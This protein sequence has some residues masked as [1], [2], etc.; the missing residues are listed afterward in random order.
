MRPGETFAPSPWAPP[1][2]RRRRW[3]RWERSAGPPA[4]ARTTSSPS[5]LKT[6]TPSF[7]QI[8]NPEDAS[9]IRLVGRYF[10]GRPLGDTPLFEWGAELVAITERGVVPVSRVVAAGDIQQGDLWT[11]LIRNGWEEAVENFGS[12]FGWHGVIS[13][14]GD[15]L[16]VN[17]PD[18]GNA[19]GYGAGRQFVRNL[20]TGAW[21][22]F[23]GQDAL[24]WTVF[25]GD[26]YF[27]R[28][29]RAVGSPAPAFGQRP[30]TT[31]NR[32]GS[33]RSARRPTCRTPSGSA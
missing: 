23:R 31:A 29:D 27:S 19:D 10:V 8:E 12:K 4:G 28:A 3:W 13:P 15:Q 1:A 25:N 11:D 6:G 5:C 32:S 18:Y 24:A 7:T 22:E 20:V 17:V 16:I 9:T 21:C 30:A 33:S 2:A 26:L 14:A